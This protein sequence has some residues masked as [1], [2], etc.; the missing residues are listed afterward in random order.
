MK[1]AILLHMKDYLWQFSK[2]QQF[3]RKG[4]WLLIARLLAMSIILSYHQ[5]A[6][7]NASFY[8]HDV[9]LG[10]LTVIM[11]ISELLLKLNNNQSINQIQHYQR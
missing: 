10:K 2:R 3:V 6:Y 9:I 4:Y 7:P 11:N 5:L 8:L 1:I